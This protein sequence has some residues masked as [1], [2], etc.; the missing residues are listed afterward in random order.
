[1]V[2]RYLG[3]ADIAGWFG[4]QTHT[5]NAWR[6]RYEDFPEPDALIGDTPGWLPE[7]EAEIRQWES[8]RPG[9]GAFGGRPRKE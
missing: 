7:R 8:N 4:V 3:S 9:Q 1:M 6:R 2:I 5:V